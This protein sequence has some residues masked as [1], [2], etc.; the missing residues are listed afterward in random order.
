MPLSHTS[1]PRPHAPS[2]GFSQSSSTKRMSF[3]V[4]IEAERVQRAEVEVEDVRRRRLQHHLVL[5]VV[6]HP[7]RVLA[8]A[9]V[10]GPAR[11][12][13]VRG[14]PGLGAERAQERR[15]VRRAGARLPCRT[16][17][18][19]RSPGR[20]SSPGAQDDLLKRVHRGCGDRVGER[21]VYRHRRRGIR[22]RERDHRVRR[23]CS[24]PEP[25]QRH[26]DRSDAR[27]ASRDARTAR[28]PSAR[29]AS[30]PAGRR[31]RPRECRA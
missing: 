5:I 30:R 23:S 26:A 8:V 15:R 22:Q 14:A 1:Q 28:R 16:A 2:V 9:A 19:A 20:P 12:L 10:L 13:H 4:E 11:R 18:A 7:V 21:A 17:A 24:A 27:G 3:F 29:T 6:L 25:G 31:S